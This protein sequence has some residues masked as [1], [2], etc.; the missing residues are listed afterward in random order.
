MSI[1]IKIDNKM[2]DMKD[3]IR[4]G[5]YDGRSRGIPGLNGI[6]VPYGEG[7][8]LDWSKPQNDFGIKIN[9]TDL[10]HYVSTVWENPTPFGITITNKD[11]STYYVA[12]YDAFRGNTNSKFPDW[13]TRY[14]VICISGGMGAEFLSQQD[15]N[16]NPISG[17]G[18]RA[19]CYGN[20]GTDKNYRVEIGS[21]GNNPSNE[22]ADNATRGFRTKFFYK[23]DIKYI[24]ENGSENTILAATAFSD[25]FGTIGSF[26]GRNN[27][28]GFERLK[29]NTNNTE[30]NKISKI[31]DYGKGGSNNVRGGGGRLGIPEN[32]CCI[33]YYFK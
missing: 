11:L 31:N 3:I 9:G 22:W 8:V 19:W 15:F 12:R 2:A 32:G 28:I 30:I 7:A 26:R 14:K 23:G 20:V 25:G 21:Q 29:Y 27:S 13:C 18:F 5:T 10:R 1:K 6:G 17:S 4:G 16:N 33:I 24:A